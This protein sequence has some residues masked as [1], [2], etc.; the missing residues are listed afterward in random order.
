MNERSQPPQGRPQLHHVVFAVEPQR[1]TTVAEMFTRLG[2]A[3]ESLELTEMGLRVHLDWHRGI[4]LISPLPGSTA[5]VAA[6]VQEFLANHGDGVYTVV[7]RV[8]QASD[9]HAVAGQYGATVRFRQHIE[10]DGS[11][12]EEIDLSVMNLALTLLDTNLP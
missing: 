1:H 7:I 6:S 3:F 10:G 2:F 4:E 11:H 9:A 12:L 5:A 8:P